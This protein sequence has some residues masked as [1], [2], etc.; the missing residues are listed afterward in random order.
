MAFLGNAPR[1]AA[2]RPDPNSLAGKARAAEAH[3]AKAHA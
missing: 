1:G 2:H 3:D